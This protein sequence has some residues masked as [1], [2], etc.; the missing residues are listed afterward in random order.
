MS[1]VTTEISPALQGRIKHRQ[2]LRPTDGTGGSPSP[3]ERPDGQP[4]RES[5]RAPSPIGRSLGW[6]SVVLGVSQLIA[7]R[8]LARLI[9]VSE[10]RHTV[11]LMRALGAREL[12]AGLALLT[13]R[14]PSRWLWARFA[15][16]MIDIGLL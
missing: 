13:R 6:F 8:R 11:N 2:P 1:Q 14:R 7:P 5:R 15:G 9:G 12:S 4:S 16:D 3:L 10:R